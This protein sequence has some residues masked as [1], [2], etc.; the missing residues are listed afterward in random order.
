[1][2][3]NKYM[4]PYTLLASCK[5]CRK[6]PYDVFLPAN[7]ILSANT[8]RIVSPLVHVVFSPTSAK[9]FLCAPQK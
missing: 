2:A 5:K 8:T 9:L 4:R 7:T 6:V 3:E 1:M